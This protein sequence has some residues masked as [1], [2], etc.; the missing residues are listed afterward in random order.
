MIK[1]ISIEEQNLWDEIVLSFVD[2]DVFYLHKYAEAFMREDHKNGI[3]I[4]LLYENGSDR[5]INVV[6]KRDVSEDD[7]MKGL[8]P[9]N[10]YFDLITPYGYG[11]FWGN[12][13][14][15]EKL[16]EEY[17]VYC[18]QNHYIC[19]FVRFELFDDYVMHYDGEFESKTHNVI[20]NLDMDMDAIWMDFKQKVRKNV[21]RAKQ[22]GLK[23]IAENTDE[24]LKEF[25]EIYYST[26][27]RNAAERNYYF[28]EDFFHNMI[29]MKDNIMMFYVLFEK[30]VISAEL[31]IFG[32]DNCYSYLGGTLRD[33]FDLRPND[34]L[35]YEII[36]WAKEK[37]LK[38]FVLGGGYGADDGIFQYKTCLA[39]QGVVAFYTGKK[40]FDVD[41]Y[42]KLVKV[43]KEE[44]S[45]CIKP[46]FFPEY[47]A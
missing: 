36:K 14:D 15:Y 10:K 43:R 34:F 8:I 21:K 24:H 11:G 27:D 26:M 30:K 18:C 23:L 13:S 35:K 47:R 6:F 22:N 42:E 1:E 12:V 20:R 2:Y 41:N 4:L 37:G 17:N 32:A 16:N 7:K 39:P 38:N 19:E 45:D 46:S 44:N 9:Q 40:I 31:V 28:S 25:L 33:Y 29:S 3:P 5:A